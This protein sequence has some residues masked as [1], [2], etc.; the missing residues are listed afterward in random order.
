[1]KDKTFQ[2]I[3]NEVLMAKKKYDYFTVKDLIQE[4]Q[5]YPEDAKVELIC[6]DKRSLTGGCE[7]FGY[8]YKVEQKSYGEREVIICGNH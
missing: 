2:S 4:L 3:L 5:K 1:M 8:P 7:G 6:F